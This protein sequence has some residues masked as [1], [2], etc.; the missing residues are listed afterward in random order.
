MKGIACHHMPSHII[1][2]AI[3]ACREIKNSIFQHWLVVS[4]YSQCVWWRSQ[5]I[6]LVPAIDPEG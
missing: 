6:D 4:H 3:K 1:Q 5:G 2:I